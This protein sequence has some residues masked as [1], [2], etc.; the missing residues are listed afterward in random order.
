MTLHYAANMRQPNLVPPVTTVAA[1]LSYKEKLEAIE[2]NVTYL[3]SLYLNSEMTPQDIIEAKKAGI[4]GVKSY[5]AGVTTNSDSGVVDY[6]DYYPVFAEMEK[7]DIV[8][9]L[10]G[11]C[12]SGKGIDI[13][14]A[15][16]KFLPTLKEI[17]SQFPKLRIV[18]VRFS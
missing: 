4:A 3:M 8:L 11:E 16:E 6:K 7:Q 1:A 10:H 17:H 12:P 14:N 9:N 15:E 13:L 5:P 18:L 2:P